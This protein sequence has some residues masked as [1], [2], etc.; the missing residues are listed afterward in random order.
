M[1]VLKICFR[2]GDEGRE[3]KGGEGRRGTEREGERGGRECKR[4]EANE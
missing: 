3:W 2:G 1:R 4:P